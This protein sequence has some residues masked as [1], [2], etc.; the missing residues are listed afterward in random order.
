MSPEEPPSESEPKPDGQDSLRNQE[1]FGA[2]VEP[3]QLHPPPDESLPSTRE[4]RGG[5]RHFDTWLSRDESGVDAFSYLRDVYLAPPAL[6]FRFLPEPDEIATF[7]GHDPNRRLSLPIP[8]AYYQDQLALP[9]QSR[10]VSSTS[11]LFTACRWL[12]EHPDS[13]A[14]REVLQHGLAA[15]AGY[16]LALAREILS[17]PANRRWFFDGLYQFLGTEAPSDSDRPDSSA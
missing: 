15:P 6:G 14:A 9:E 7:F 4:P 13:S 5:T 12:R 8:L 11:A 10:R 3:E 17:K 2:G 16:H 1:P